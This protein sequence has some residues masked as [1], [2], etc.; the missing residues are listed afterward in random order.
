MLSRTPLYSAHLKMAARMVDFG[1]WEMPLHYGSQIAEHH[2]VRRQCAM[3]DV[4]HMTIIDIKGEGASS[5]LGYLLA[6]DTN[7]LA[8]SRQALYSVMLN[9]EGGVID[10][11]MAYTI[12][13]GYRLVVNSA[14]RA[15][16]LEW[17]RAKAS[18]F[19]VLIEERA[20]LA[21]IAIQGPEAVT[22]VQT[23]V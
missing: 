6:N 14:T 4:S 3:F 11:L 1:G 22:K 16:D 15:R 2:S 10:D 18:A 23:I 21:M 17:M 19:D 20:D 9:E 5:Y 7:K 13:D 8:A 12:D